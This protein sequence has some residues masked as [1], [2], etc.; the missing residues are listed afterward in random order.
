M[1]FETLLEEAIEDTGMRILFYCI[2]P[3]HR[4]LALYPREDKDMG[5][6]MRLLTTTHVCQRRVLTSTVGQGHLYQGAY[7]S[8]PVETDIHLLTLI[9]YI[10]QNPMRARLVSRAEEWPWSSLWRRVKGNNQQKKILTK[11]PI[12]LPEDYLEFVN[13]LLEVDKMQDIRKSV[14]KG[15]PFGSKKWVGNIV[16]KYGLESTIRNPGRPPRV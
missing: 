3:N 11:L 2:M 6:F 10:E 4:H 5:E 8:F 1:H 7:K 13:T 15:M 16:K 14:S 12:S 9:R